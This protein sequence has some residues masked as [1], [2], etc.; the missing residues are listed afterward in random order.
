MNEGPNGNLKS[1]IQRLTEDIEVLSQ[2]SS[3]HGYFDQFQANN[4]SNLQDSKQESEENQ[5]ETIKSK[6]KI[7]N[8]LTL[9]EAL[10]INNI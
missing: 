5:K 9:E 2:R 3:E 10:D 7:G 4:Q 8:D 6:F 1:K